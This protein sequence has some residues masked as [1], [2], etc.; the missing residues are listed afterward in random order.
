HAARARGPHPACG[1]QRARRGRERPQEGQLAG[2][3]RRL[4]RRLRRNHRVRRSHAERQSTYRRG[5]GSLRR[6]LVRPQGSQLREKS[7]I[8]NWIGRVFGWSSPTRSATPM[9]PSLM[10]TDAAPPATSIVDSDE[11]A[12]EL[13]RARRYEHDLSIVVLSARPYTHGSR[14]SD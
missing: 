9:L 12:A 2:V 14:A 13:A 8:T 7:M 4:L 11:L 3:L 6:L 1:P 10:L 5:G